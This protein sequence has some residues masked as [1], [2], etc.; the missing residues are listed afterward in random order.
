MSGSE[1]VTDR[2]TTFAGIDCDGRARHIMESIERKF[3]ESGQQQ[4]FLN[5]FLAK[6]QPKSGPIPDDLFLI[7]SN[8]NQ[9]REFFEECADQPMLDLLFL[10]EEECC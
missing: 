10:L 8:I 6:K 2:Y 4:L 7:H 3:L 1:K 5:Y 9:I